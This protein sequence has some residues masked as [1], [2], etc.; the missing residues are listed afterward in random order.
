MTESEALPTTG[1]ATGESRNAVVAELLLDP[2][3][4][5]LPPELQ[6]ASQIELAQYIDLHYEPI[7]VAESIARRGYFPSEPLI[8]QRET[9]LV[10]EGNRR[11]VALRGLSDPALRATFDDPA[12]W[13]AAAAL[14]PSPEEVPVVEVV[15]RSDAAAVIGYRHISGVEPWE[16]MQKARFIA[17]LL[18]GPDA[19]DFATVADLVG[20]TEHSVRSQ[21]RNFVAVREMETRFGEN[22]TRVKN[23]FGTFTRAMQSQGVR[24]FLGTP[25]PSSVDVG[26]SVLPDGAGERAAELSSWLFGE[27]DGTDPV[28]SDSRKIS[29]LGAIIQSEDGLAE[30]RKTRSLEAAFEAGGGPRQRLLNRLAQARNALRAAQKDFDSHA[31]DDEVQVLLEE[32]AEALDDLR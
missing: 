18:E 29:D 14:G 22:T 9:N 30:L 28:I 24:E 31:G 19:S 3:N 2:D 21:Y 20:E 25:A 4:P 8:V 5:R 32:C 7:R 15:E 23:H 16:P 26:G 6:G 11:L 17:S 10:L 27:E 1:L 12:A 13:E